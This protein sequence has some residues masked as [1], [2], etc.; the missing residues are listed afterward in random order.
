MIM[1][2]TA[3]QLEQLALLDASEHVV[4]TKT[5]RTV[6]ARPIGN[7]DA[8]LLVD[9]YSRLSERPSRMAARNWLGEKRRD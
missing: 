9:L 1:S 8:P 6:V 2:N 4:T 7:A 5:G 3:I